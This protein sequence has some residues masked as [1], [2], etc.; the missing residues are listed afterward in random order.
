VG[1]ALVALPLIS[2]LGFTSAAIAPLLLMVA[3]MTALRRSTAYG[4]VSP[5]YSVLFSQATREQ[6]YKARAV[7]DTVIFRTGDL[8]GSLAFS[9]LLA[10]GLGLRGTAAVSATVAIPWLILA[11]WLT[12]NKAGGH[13]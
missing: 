3:G 6:K 1:P 13:P 12:R 9:G 5:A 2:G 11:W 7:I 8:V 10:L 4:L